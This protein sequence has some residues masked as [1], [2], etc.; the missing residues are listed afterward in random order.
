[1][2]ICSKC[3]ASKDESEFSKDKRAKDGMQGR[4]KLCSGK[5]NKEYFDRHRDRVAA[6]HK[7][8]A[9]KYAKAHPDRIAVIN[10]RW[11]ST[12]QN[13]KTNRPDY[14]PRDREKILKGIKEGVEALSDKYVRDQL[15]AQEWPKEAITPDLIEVKRVLLKFKRLKNDKEKS[16]TG[17]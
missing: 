4:C 5:A 17:E 11:R 16:N 2:K 7:E 15:I 13:Y 14:Y 10:K 6:A 1:M 9:R 8:S 3:G 12:N